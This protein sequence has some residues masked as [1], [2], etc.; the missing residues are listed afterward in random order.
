MTNDNIKK[1]YEYRKSIATLLAGIETSVYVL[2][3]NHKKI[4]VT[5]M[6]EVIALIRDE[7]LARIDEEIAKAEAKVD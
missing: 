6:V 4:R 7:C 1:A 5:D 2:A 3:G